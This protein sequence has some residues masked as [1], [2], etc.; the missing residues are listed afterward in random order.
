MT[1]KMP[2]LRKIKKRCKPTQKANAFAPHLI[3][4]QHTQ[5]HPPP[6]KWTS[7]F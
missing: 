2:T 4:P 6:N 7:E 1:D 3:L 5:A